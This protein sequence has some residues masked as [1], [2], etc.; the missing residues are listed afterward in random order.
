MW[1]WLFH[2]EYFFDGCSTEPWELLEGYEQF[3]VIKQ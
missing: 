2:M 3:L 1:L